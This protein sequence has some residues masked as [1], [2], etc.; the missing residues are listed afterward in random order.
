MQELT[1][2][3]YSEIKLH[4]IL[5]IAYEAIEFSTNKKEPTI[6][7]LIPILERQRGNPANGGLVHKANVHMAAEQGSR[8]LIESPHLLI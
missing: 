3:Y 8:W 4:N 6:T 1:N 5:H 7:F 2:G